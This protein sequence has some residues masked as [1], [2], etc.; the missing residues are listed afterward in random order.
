MGEEKGDDDMDNEG[1]Q[2]RLAKNVVP[3]KRPGSPAKGTIPVHNTIATHKATANISSPSPLFKLL[4]VLFFVQI[5]KKNGMS[6]PVLSLGQMF[7][8]FVS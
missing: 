1:L 2:H 6:S 7:S 4:F 8:T 3:I 5:T